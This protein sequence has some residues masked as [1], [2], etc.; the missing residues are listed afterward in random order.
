MSAGGGTRPA[1][2]ALA[3]TVAGLAIGC[4]GNPGEETP[5]DAPAA[6]APAEP[7]PAPAGP[8]H[9]EFAEV[10]GAVGVD[11]V[12]N[13]GA[14][15]E[16][17][18]PETMGSG[19]AW[20]DIDGDGDPD[21]LILSG[22]DF[23]GH[24]SDRRQA[25]ALY[26]NDD[27]TFTDVTRA[28]GLGE[29]MYAMGVT[30][31]DYDNDGDVD[32]YVTTLGRNRLY[33]NDGGRFT[34]VAAQ[35]GV[36]DDGFGSSASWLDYDRDGDLDLFT[37]NYVTWS[38]E[39]DIFCSLDGTNK[40]YCTPE[41][42]TGAVSRL[43][44]NDG[45][46]FTD[47]TR[48]AGLFDETGKAL[49]IVC[50]DLDDDGWED[51]F[52]AQDTQPNLLWRNLG[53]G[54]FEEQGMIAGVAFDESGRAR[55]AM[56]VDASDYDGTGRP[57][58]TIGNFSNEMLALYHNEGAGFFIDS[59][60]TSAV[61]RESLLTLAFGAFFADFDL[62]G[63]PD[64]FVANGHV[65]NEIQKVQSRVSYAQPAHLFRNLGGGRFEDTA[66]DDEALSHP[67][68]GRGSAYADYDG[69]GDLDFAV[70]TSGSRFRLLRNDGADGGR[71][72]RVRLV[73]DA[74]S[75]PQGYGA[76]VRVTAA[77]H[78][79]TSWM[80][81]AHSYASQS[82]AVLTFGLGEAGSAEELEVRWPSGKTTRLRDVDAG[83]RLT[84]RESEAG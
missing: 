81:A 52:V 4:G 10:A 62:D 70:V 38:P 9:V 75:N 3:L 22:M 58:L 74:G 1:A 61:G 27:G 56:G 2:V 54:T 42:Y 79:Q 64:I 72:V 11:F 35:L 17:W 82:E 34:D 7:A 45:D 76:R 12:H 20:P 24:G 14:F 41:A 44:R 50:L 59:A 16:K 5:S 8:A 40:S 51:V 15:G 47:V 19:C 53:D 73:G 80:R 29:P 84:L 65:E 77:G 60:P 31:G 21:L 63:R 66:P 49:G 18:L 37:L 83:A 23:Q 13:T 78:T 6:A 67:I 69:D 55:G 39:T 36:D 32:L 25:S 33:R 26:R 46:R 30:Y 68:V 57:S 43:Y 71:S 48:E 28:A